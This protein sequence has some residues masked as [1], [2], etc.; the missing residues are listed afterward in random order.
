MP[1]T[2][3]GFL[4]VAGIGFVATANFNDHGV[5]RWPSGYRAM[6]VAVPAEAPRGHVELS[7]YGFTDLDPEGGPPITTLH[8][9]IAVENASDH[10]P[11]TIDYS[12]TTLDIRGESRVT[13]AFINGEA[14]T[15]PYVTIERGQHALADLYFP[16]PARMH[17]EADLPSFDVT[18]QVAT[19]DRL[20][21]SRTRFER[22]RVGVAATTP[23]PPL[24]RA[25]KWWFDPGYSWS[26][27][28]HR[29]GYAV[30]RPPRHV[31]IARPR[32]TTN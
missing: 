26:T 17:G 22:A 2:T 9:R 16:L 11:W 27:Y 24:G 28:Y 29:P 31:T 3:F 15:L 25:H 19:P 14:A 21:E 32:V 4:A 13:A 6:T 12:R 7:S 30:P 8:V 20:L 1:H 10:V 18:W 5:S 23:T